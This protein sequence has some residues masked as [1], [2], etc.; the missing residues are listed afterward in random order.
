LV[1]CSYPGS[2]CISTIEPH[3][4]GIP[5]SQITTLELASG[6]HWLNGGLIGAS[7]G[8]VLGG[9]FVLLNDGLCNTAECRSS[10]P[11]T[12]VGLTIFGFGLGALFGASS[13]R[14]RLA[15]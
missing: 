3:A 11:R 1:F 10:G 9:A 4:Q 12:A 13:P 5:A 2:P 6:S 14:W 7:V 8:V 15:P